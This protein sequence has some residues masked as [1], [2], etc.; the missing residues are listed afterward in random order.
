MTVYVDF[1]REYPPKVVDRHARKHGVQWCHMFSDDI[2]ELHIFARGIGLQRR[3]F[4]TSSL[5][6]HYDLTPGKRNLALLRG[7]K[8]VH[9][10]EFLRK[11]RIK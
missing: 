6:P 1:L 3:Y 7:A 11:Q 4:Q 10:I 2:E 8:Q 5:L 9:L